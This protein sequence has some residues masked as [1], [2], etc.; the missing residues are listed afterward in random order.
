[1]TKNEL[2]K[3]LYKI[4]PDNKILLIT[5]NDLDGSG[6]V[7]ILNKF[8]KNVIVRHVTNYAMSWTIIKAVTEELDET[9]EF[10]CVVACDI[11]V[12]EADAELIENHP[13]HDRFVLIDHHA[14]AE[15]LNKYDWAAV[16]SKLLDDSF[17]TIFYEGISEDKPRSSSGTSLLYDYVD[18]LGLAKDADPE[19]KLF[20]HMIATYDTWDWKNTFTGAE[21][22]YD[23]N[24]LF[25]IYGSEIFDRL[26]TERFTGMNE[27]DIDNF[28]KQNNLVLEIENRKRENFLQY[29]DKGFQTGS[30]KIG[31]K[32]Y[33]MCL[34]TGNSY[35]NDV[36]E[37]MKEHWPNRDL[38]IICYGTGISYRSDNPDINVGEIS[39]LYGGG[40]HVAA[41]GF[42]IPLDLQIGYIQAAMTDSTVYIDR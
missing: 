19:F 13:N 34:W 15:F 8:F 16:E 21:S 22:C 12:N 2:F 42:K 25:N 35:M 24:T 20:I 17:R 7:V 4:N 18:Y 32:C 23:L 27:T 41:G 26:Y 33:S 39:K 36:F 10:D 11:S 3:N 38:Y 37:R 14:T 30:V 9:E 29:V 40:G 6:P 28:N 1:M 5:H 31:D